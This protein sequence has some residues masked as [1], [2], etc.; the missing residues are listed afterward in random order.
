M[1]KKKSQK[2]PRRIAV[3]FTEGQLELIDQLVEVNV[4]GGNRADVINQIVMDYLK[5]TGKR[6]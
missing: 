1:P 2:T 6:S 3:T 4:L 5:D